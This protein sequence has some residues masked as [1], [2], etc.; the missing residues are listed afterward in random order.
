MGAI[1]GR[2]A[3]TGSVGLEALVAAGEVSG[4]GSMVAGAEAL[5]AVDEAPSLVEVVVE[6]GTSAPTSD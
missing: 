2:L 5:V 3:G 1:W 4:I 6:V